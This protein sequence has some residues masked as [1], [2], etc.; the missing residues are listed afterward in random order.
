M[1]IGVTMLQQ[2]AFVRNSVKIDTIPQAMIITSVFGST[3]NTEN[4]FPK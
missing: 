1:T 2:A 3:S 4:L